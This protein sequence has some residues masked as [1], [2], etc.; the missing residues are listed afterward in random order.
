LHDVS[1]KINHIIK[2]S[3]R[4]LT[5]GLG[6]DDDH[7]N[8]AVRHTHLHWTIELRLRAACFKNVDT[9]A[10]KIVM[11]TFLLYRRLT[12]TFYT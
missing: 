1:S 2:R 12:R 10:T 3:K 7:K 4:V 6:V 8:K 9:T 5:T 11:C